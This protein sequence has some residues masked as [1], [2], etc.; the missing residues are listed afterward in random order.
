[1]EVHTL[2]LGSLMVSAYVVTDGPQAILIDAPEDSEQII[3]FCDARGLVPHTLINTHGHFDHICGNGILK[4]H[5]PEMTLAAPK[6]DLSMLASPIK[7]LSIML[8]QLVR[9]P[10]ADRVLVGGDTVIL[11]AATLEVL[12]TP[13]HSAGGISLFTRQGPGGRPAVFTGDALFA[14]SVGRTDFPGSSAKTLENSL[15]TRL[16]TLP[17]ETA[18]YPGHGPAT[19]IGQEAATNPY[20]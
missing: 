5:W 14:G 20:L 4:S 6:A 8:G 7:N 16:L 17:P 9:S 18:V 11:G 10:K 3:A 13:G 12:E 1:M 15:R 19:T 2:T